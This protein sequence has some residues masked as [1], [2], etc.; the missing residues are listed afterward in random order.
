M[1]RSD[2]I[3]GMVAFAILSALAAWAITFTAFGH[4]RPKV[5]KWR[6]EYT[7]YSAVPIEVPARIV[8]RGVEYDCVLVEG[9][10]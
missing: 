3:W 6:E 2:A 4:H 1:N 5:A 10:E 8:W 7:P 9:E